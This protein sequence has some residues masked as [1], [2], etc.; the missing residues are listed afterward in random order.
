MTTKEQKKQQSCEYNEIAAGEDIA[1][2]RL[3]STAGDWGE[4]VRSLVVVVIVAV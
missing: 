3:S 4:C 1:G 2:G